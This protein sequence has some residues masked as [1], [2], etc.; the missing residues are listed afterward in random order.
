MISYGPRRVAAFSGIGQIYS[1]KS[2]RFGRGTG[3]DFGYENRVKACPLVSAAVRDAGAQKGDPN[4]KY[5]FITD[6][7]SNL[8]ALEAV[9]ADMAQRGVDATYH[10]GD[11]VGYAPWPN[12]TVELLRQ[13]DI[14]GLEAPAGRS[15]PAGVPRV[16]GRALDAPRAHFPRSGRQ[17]DLPRT[18]GCSSRIILR[19]RLMPP[20]SRRY[21]YMP[22]L[23]RAPLSFLPRL[24]G[25]LLH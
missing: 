10:L 6:I 16:L 20:A 22:R 19:V 24:A 7:H 3:Y 15:H 14:A 17:A 18:R 2:V 13:H 5:A 25:R 21:R 9:L 8:P 1:W 11:L 12:E 4:M 23:T